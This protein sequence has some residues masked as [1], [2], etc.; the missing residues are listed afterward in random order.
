MKSHVISGILTFILL[1]TGCSSSGA[2]ETDWEPTD[3]EEVNNFTGVSMS[4]IEESVSKTGVTVLI[5][6]DSDKKVL[7][8]A[9]Y[10]LEKKIND[11]WYQ[12]P[13]TL[14]EN[15]GFE[16][17]GYTVLPDAAD[18]WKT[19]WSGIYDTLESGEYRIVKDVIDF[20]SSGDYD[21]YDLAA[22]FEINE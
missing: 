15:Y 1:L 18:E 6:N 10:V 14:E 8:G 21:K 16:D 3:A 22:E 11:D 9:S 20:R 19:S 4:V 5:E 17:V 7:Y 13:I 12:V 2:E